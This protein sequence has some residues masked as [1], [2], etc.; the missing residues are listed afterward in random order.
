MPALEVNPEGLDVLA[1]R[2]TALAVEV[3][4]ASSVTPENPAPNQ[5]SGAAVLTL[6]TGVSSAARALADRLVSTSQ[7]L[8]A[9]GAAFLSHEASAAADLTLVSSPGV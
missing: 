2:C 3:T 5:A 9:G 1:M 6:H 7:K 8:A 4:S